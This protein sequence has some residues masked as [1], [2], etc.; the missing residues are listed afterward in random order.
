MKTLFINL[1]IRPDAKR[2]L[3]P[4]GLGYVMTAVQKA[5]FEFDFLDIDIDQLTMIEVKEFLEKNSY[6]I[7]AF[8]CIVTGYKY[9]REIA[10]EIKKINRQATIVAGN[11][12]ATSIPELL[13]LNTDVD[14]AVLGEGD[15]TMVE[16]LRAIDK[17]S[18]YRHV[19]GIAFQ[20]NG[21]VHFSPDRPVEPEL[22]PFGFPDWNIFDLDKYRAYGHVN[23]NA[24][25][26]KSA[27]AFPLNSGR[28]CP[29]ACTF[30]YHVF[31]GKKY[32]RYTESS[33]VNEIRRLHSQYGASYIMFW[34]E[35][36]FPHIKAVR[37]LLEQ[38]AGLDFKIGWD[39]AC[40]AG[41]FK[42]EDLELIRDMRSLGCENMAFSLENG[43]EEILLA[44]N[45]KI[46]T[47]QFIEQADAL[48]KGGVPPRTSVIFGYPQETK[49]SIKQ[50]LAICEQCN[51]FPSVGFLLPL[52]GTPIYQW[53]KESG[54]IQDEIAYL[55]GIGDRQDFHINLTAMND[56][57]FVGTVKDGL[58]QLAKKQG[59][60]FESVF[61]TVT[62]QKPNVFALATS[63]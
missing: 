24:F 17:N 25:F 30:C 36:T 49:E 44:M 42:K 7:Y 62:Y 23:S 51:I 2:R 27:Q 58:E 10:A 53:A 63:S 43:S 40:R 35:L 21:E 6:D 3:L 47:A 4:V 46:T 39:A 54:H 9:V 48:W 29:H 59:L 14:I 15:V 52:P 12:V 20:D 8:G 34:D 31:R 45:K 1:S 56:E 19:A 38:I 18:G 26:S 16:L 41:L 22:D 11:S 13:L 37:A 5:G 61:K 33:I 50:T 60:E 55:E 32:R 57:E 28:G